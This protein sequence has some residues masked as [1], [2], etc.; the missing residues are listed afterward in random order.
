MSA[1]PSDQISILIT[2]LA[3]AEIEDHIASRI[4]MTFAE[5]AGLVVLYD[6]HLVQC[7]NGIDIATCKWNGRRFGAFSRHG[8]IA[9]L[10][11]KLVAAGAPDAPWTV[12]GRIGGGS[13][14]RLADGTVTIVETDGGKFRF[15]EAFNA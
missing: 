7:S 1:K 10:A 3:E 4:V 5:R 8:A 13:L 2:L 15:A 9:A 6:M 14:D 11:S 12:F